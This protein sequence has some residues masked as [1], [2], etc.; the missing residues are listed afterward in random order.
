[1]E[2]FDNLRGLVDDMRQEILQLKAELKAE[3]INTKE[4]LD[5]LTAE[6]EIIKRTPDRS[7]DK[8]EIGKGM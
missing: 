5:H 6:N 4:K 2:D 1:M 7:S 3:H 8:L